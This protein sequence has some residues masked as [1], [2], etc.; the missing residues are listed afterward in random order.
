MPMLDSE[1]VT[2]ITVGDPEGLAS[3][4]DK[5]AGPLFT[6]CRTLLRDPADAADAVQDTF[7]IAASRLGS[8]REPDRLRTWLY[9]VAR[10]ECARTLG[11]RR[12]TAARGES[13]E[14]TD[15]AA[16]VPERARLRALF[17]A[18]A[19]GLNPGEREVVEL[20]LRHGLDP[21]EVTSVLGVSRSRSH[22]LLARAREQ[23]ETCL[24]VL[25]VGRT[26]R[27]DCRE[28]GA[29]L[30]G[31]DGKLTVPLRKRLHQHIGRCSTC[32]ARRAVELRPASLFDLSAG[33]ALAAGAAESFRLAPGVPA[34]LKAHTI[35]LATGHGPGSAAHSAA[36]L[37]R[38]G[39][40]T[41]HGFPKPTGGGAGK[42]GAPRHRGGVQGGLRSPQGQAAVAASVVLAVA[43][44]AITITLSGNS[45]HVTT[46]SESKPSAPV[47][48]E[49]VP[50]ET[51]PSETGP[52]ETG[53]SG[54]GALP[55]ASLGAR[56]PAGAPSATGL[57][58]VTPVASQT[59]PTGSSAPAS[60]TPTRPTSSAPSTPATPSRSPTARP[61]TTQA[62]GK[63]LV[64]PLGGTLRVMPGTHG[65]SVYLR[66]SGGPVA[67]SVT[68]A[69][70]PEG[71]ISVS[72]GYSGKLTTASPQVTLEIAADQYL[73]CGPGG[74]PCPTVTVNPGGTVYTIWTEWGHQ[75]L[76]QAEAGRR[77]FLG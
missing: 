7:V 68:V 74:S 18:A 66:A 62:P 20:Q 45:D 69:N 50:A 53:P 14:V 59:Q 4:Y 38:T 75:H 76:S 47:P 19:V 23:L 35:A 26:G 63:L 49:T 15:H 73:N 33:A 11:S 2:S 9:A 1:V 46:V 37:S 8:L 12:R 31:W 60:A 29:M 57:S 24:G 58:L 42:A 13:P 40:F 34:G 65:T 27:A 25:L 51:G 30:D 5:Y 52:S 67:W 77:A 41:S 6:Y 72:P 16:S 64:W 44:A 54:S 3:A 71:A 10:N 22:A 70:D 48:S 56:K 43:V 39:A 36:V 17:E 32:S 55:T 28:L 61:T 21:A